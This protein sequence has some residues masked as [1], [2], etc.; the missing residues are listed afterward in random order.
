MNLRKI[1]VVLAALVALATPNLAEARGHGACDGIHRCTCGSTQTRH[2]GFPRIYNGVNLWQARGWVEAFQRTSLRAGVVG[3]VRHG[4]PTGHVFRVVQPTG[5][6]TALVADERGTYERNLSGAIFVDPSGNRASPATTMYH[7]KSR[8]GHP[9]Q[10]AQF[11][12][13]DRL[14]VH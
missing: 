13:V 9:M 1:T 8:K 12:P 7:A 10:V 14:T 3:Y 4:G 5:P 11:V 6:N 2:F